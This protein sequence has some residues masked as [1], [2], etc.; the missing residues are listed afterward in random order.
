MIP[1]TFILPALSLHTHT[2]TFTPR[3]V[4]AVSI[5]GC[6]I[7]FSACKTCKFPLWRKRTRRER[8]LWYDARGGEFK[9]KRIGLESE[10]VITT[11]EQNEELPHDGIWVTR[12]IDVDV[13]PSQPFLILDGCSLE[14]RSIM[15]LQGET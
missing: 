10:C 7:K 6:I 8:E 2:T 15:L 4:G 1:A 12:T 14:G 11:A 13:L 9:V 5:R 3:D